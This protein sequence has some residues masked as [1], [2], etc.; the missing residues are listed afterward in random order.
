MKEELKKMIKEFKQK[1][2]KFPELIILSPEDLA[3]LREDLELS[4]EV[5]LTEFDNIKL[6]VLDER[7]SKL[8]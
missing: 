3:Q 4:Y 6:F 2:N 5:D 7:T 1:K 8:Y